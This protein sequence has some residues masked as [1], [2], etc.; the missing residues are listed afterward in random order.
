MNFKI[1]KKLS[2]KLQRGDE[3]ELDFKI[4]LMQSRK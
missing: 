1:P 2:M 3:N 4:T